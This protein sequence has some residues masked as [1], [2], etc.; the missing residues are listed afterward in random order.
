MAYTSSATDKLAITIDAAARTNLIRQ[1]PA[2]KA[3]YKPPPRPAYVGGADWP[4]AEEVDEAYVL[5]GAARV[6]LNRW[7]LPGS[8]IPA[9]KLFE[10]VVGEKAKGVEQV[11][12]DFLHDD[13]LRAEALAAHLEVKVEDVLSCAVCTGLAMAAGDHE[14][15]GPFQV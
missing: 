2:V 8:S 9:A 11:V 7:T 13:L 15:H 3:A 12:V 6:G 4:G 5:T 14:I 1:I 10:P